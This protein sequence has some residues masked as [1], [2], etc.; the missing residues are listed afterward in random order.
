MPK[1]PANLTRGL[2]GWDE[3]HTI[4]RSSISMSGRHASLLSDL[5]CE[6]RIGIVVRLVFRGNCVWASRDTNYCVIFIAIALF[7]S[8][9][10]PRPRTL[11]FPRL[12]CRLRE[13]IDVRSS[14]E[15]RVENL[16]INFD[17]EWHAHSCLS[18]N[19]HFRDLPWPSEGYVFCR[20]SSKVRRRFVIKTRILPSRER[21]SCKRDEVALRSWV[22]LQVLHILILC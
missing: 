9:N 8:P 10:D 16:P 3:R 12:S 5:M 1:E 22:R 20:D 15:N 21:I 14:V 6:R 13:P 2:P 11:P 17:K 7:A 19:Y 18:P 4:V